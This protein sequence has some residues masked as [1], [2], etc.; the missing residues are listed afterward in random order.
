MS[1]ANV[2]FYCSKLLASC[3]LLLFS[4]SFFFLWVDIVGLEYLWTDRVSIA[5]SQ[6]CIAELF[7]ITK[8]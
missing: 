8:Q 7:L 1:V 2:F 6:P 5:L 3:C 4:I